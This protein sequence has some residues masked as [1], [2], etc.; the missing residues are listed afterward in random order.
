MSDAPTPFAQPAPL[1]IDFIADMVCPWCYLG[2][3]R[4]KSALSQRPLVRADIKWRPYQLDPAIPEPGVDRRA[5]MARKFPDA[6]RLVQV[7]DHLVEAGAEEDIVFRFDRI[8]LSPNTL[9]AHRLVHWSQAQGVQ[10]AVLDALFDGY[11]TQGLDI[12]APEVLADIAA[13]AGMD[14]LDVLNRLAQGADAETVASDHKMARE[15]GVTG[16]PFIIFDQ[17]FSV[18]GAET[19]AKLLRVIDHALAHQSRDPGKGLV[20]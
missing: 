10:D 2:W 17:Q 1:T 11:F 8:A 9:A 13:G 15:A 16:V 6:Q 18:I 19:P 3:R 7:H 4:L 12:G 14:G 20:H 5:Y